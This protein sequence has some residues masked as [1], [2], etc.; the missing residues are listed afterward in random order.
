MSDK[1]GAQPSDDLHEIIED[2]HDALEERAAPLPRLTAQER[3]PRDPSQ[4]S[5]HRPN[6]GPQWSREAA[7]A[8][9]PPKDPRDIEWTAQREFQAL[10]I[11]RYKALGWTHPQIAEA[12]TIGTATITR[13]ITHP[14]YEKAQQR[15]RDALRREAEEALLEGG[16][17]AIGALR[18]ILESARAKAEGVSSRDVLS[19][20]TTLLQ[21][22][23]RYTAPPTER[24][25]ATA[26]KQ[27]LARLSPAL[28]AQVVAELQG[29]DDAYLDGLSLDEID[30]LLTE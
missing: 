10:K 4:E 15:A 24:Q 12:L 9:L 5:W 29:A 19:A 23:Q 1:Q 17:E 27:L 21:A 2:L 11:A 26:R 22:Q 25:A 6:V 16:P 30:A 13:I 14:E 3:R 28:R 7:K 8:K 18:G 20:A